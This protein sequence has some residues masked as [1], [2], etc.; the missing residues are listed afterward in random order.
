MREIVRCE[1]CLNPLLKP[2]FNLGTHPLPDDLVKLG[3]DRHCNEYPLE[4]LYCAEC[5]T[6]HQRWQLPRRQLF[7]PEYH[8]RGGQ[9]KDVL[10]GMEQLVD[11]VERRFSVSGARVLDVGCNDG[12]LLDAFARRGAI[13]Y[14]IEPTLAAH[15]C[16]KKHPATMHTFFDPAGADNFMRDFEPPDVITFTNVF[17]HIEHLDDLLEAVHTVC[18]KNTLLVIENHYLGS[19]IDRHQFDTFYHEHLR[20]YSVTSFEHIANRLGMKIVSVEFPARYGGNVR[21]MMVPGKSDHRW[22]L[23]LSAHES[24]FGQRLVRMGEDIAGWKVRKR[25]EILDNHPLFAVAFPTRASILLRLLRLTDDHIRGVYEKTGSKKIGHYAPGT[26]IPILDDATYQPDTEP[27]PP[28]L[29][30]AW[31]IPAEI[32]KRWREK[33]LRESLYPVISEGDFE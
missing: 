26:R 1:V 15:E 16:A 17:A 31:H 12:S 18:H 21:V 23:Q 20:T 11:A 3:E 24:N 33:G 2:A 32:D 19:V 7:F 9:T 25:K 10:N 28:L 13:T 27:G 6:A 30:M 5:N 22:D 14:G 4:V 29:N 8:Y